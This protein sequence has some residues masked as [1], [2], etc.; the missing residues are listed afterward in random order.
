MKKIINYLKRY[1]ECFYRFDLYRDYFREPKLLAVLFVIPLFLLFS[2]QTYFGSIGTPEF[3]EKSLDPYYDLISNSTYADVIDFE[4]LEEGEISPWSVGEND[5]LNLQFTDSKFMLEQNKPFVK[6]IEK[7]G[8]K[9]NLVIDTENTLGI[10][11]N[12]KN[13]Y[14]DETSIALGFNQNDMVAYVTDTFVILEINDA[15]YSYDLTIYNGSFDTTESIYHFLKANYVD[16]MLIIQFSMITSLFLLTMYYLV[17]YFVMRSLLKR[18]NFSLSRDRKLKIIF[19]TMQPG[20]YVYIIL[21]FF[22]KQSNFAISFIVPLLS[23]LTMLF[24]NTKTI[25]QVK[26]Y[27]KKEQKA[28]KRLKQNQ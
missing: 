16:K 11:L 15:V 17:V 21:T 1:Y 6:E 5:T 28:E 27:I 10:E 19:Y 2:L 26:D 25:D 18:H 20:L 22:M 3:V 7:D 4:P 12:A 23:V 24:I 14:S 8:Y 13:E 9:Y